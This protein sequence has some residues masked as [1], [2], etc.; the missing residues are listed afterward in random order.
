ME[1]EITEGPGKQRTWGQPKLEEVRNGI[2]PRVWWQSAGLL[3]WWF[4]TSGLQ[5]LER[6]YFCYVKLLNGSIFFFF[7]MEGLGNWFR[8]WYQ[9]WIATVWQIP[10]NMEVALELDKR[11]GIK[12]KWRVL[13]INVY[14][15]R[16]CLHSHKWNVAK[17][18]NGKSL[19]VFGRSSNEEGNSNT[20]QYSCLENPMDGRAW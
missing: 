4:C 13:S 3:T 16:G 8:F 15:L 18:M 7:L 2:S 9:K 14:H 1:D 10:E 11:S 6:A 17:N 20:L 12:K 19:L 5:N